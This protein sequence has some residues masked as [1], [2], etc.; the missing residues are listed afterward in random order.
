MQQRVAVQHLGDL[1]DVDVG[2]CRN[3]GDEKVRTAQPG[4]GLGGESTRVQD[5]LPGR[6]VPTPS[7]ASL[8]RGRRGR[9]TT[10]SAP[11]PGD[12]RASVACLTSARRVTRRDHAAMVFEAMKRLTWPRSELVVQ[13][14]AGSASS[15]WRRPSTPP[16]PR[17]R[18]RCHPPRAA[19]RRSRRHRAATSGTG[20]VARVGDAGRS[21]TDHPGA[22]YPDLTVT[23]TY[24]DGDVAVHPWVETATPVATG[25]TAAA[26]PS[27]ATPSPSQA[28]RS[29]SRCSRRGRAGRVSPD[30][31]GA[32]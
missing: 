28:T 20:P 16:T 12:P 8:A 4:T 25:S 23:D 26:G 11:R 3:G 5:R 19:G 7:S 31:R 2:M 21:E 13:P 22:A 1:V 30:H 6:G 24:R 29:P 18:R 14:P 9:S 15:T 10:S 27:S 17:L 32:R